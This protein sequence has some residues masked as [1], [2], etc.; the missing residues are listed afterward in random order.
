MSLGTRV[1]AAIACMML[2]TI[3]GALGLRPAELT[4]QSPLTIT[5]TPTSVAP[6]ATLTVTIANG[7]G[8]AKDWVGLYTTTAADTSMI[9][10]KYLNGQRL[11]PASG[12]TSATVT[13]SAP[14]NGQYNV[15][16]FPNDGIAH[17]AV[18]A[19]ITVQSAATTTS[20]AVSP[21]VVAAGGIIS[22]TIS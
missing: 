14:A 18:S 9:D 1:R 10:W 4:A 21:A 16:F 22:A 19:T 13:F 5:V 8:N 3:A 20:I 15:R 17:T 11:A 7:P 2:I 12:V 6:G